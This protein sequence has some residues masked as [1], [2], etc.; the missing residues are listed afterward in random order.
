MGRNRVKRFIYCCFCKIFKEDFQDTIDADETTVELRLCANSNWNK[1]SV[2]LLRPA[3]GKVGKPKHNFK[4]HLFGGIS[5]QGLTPLIMFTGTMYSK[6]YQNF[7]MASILPFIHKKMTNEPF[8]ASDR[9]QEMR[10]AK[11]N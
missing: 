5:R 7:L 3:G 2:G 10:A 6:D 9:S 4:I 8:R 1:P 11:N